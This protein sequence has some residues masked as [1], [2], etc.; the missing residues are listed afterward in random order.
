MTHISQ[1]NHLTAGAWAACVGRETEKQTSCRLKCVCSLQ[2]ESVKTV[3]S[4]SL[5]VHFG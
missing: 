2:F 4:V 1:D 5:S 3:H